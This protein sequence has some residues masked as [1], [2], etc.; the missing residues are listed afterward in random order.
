VVMPARDIMVKS[1]TPPGST[2]KAF[3]FVSTGFSVGGTLGP[4]IFASMMDAGLPQAIFYSS[5]VLMMLNIALAVAASN[6]GRR[7][8]AAQPAE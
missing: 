4:L 8:I 5:A 3:G 2:G 7:M 1:L 6:A